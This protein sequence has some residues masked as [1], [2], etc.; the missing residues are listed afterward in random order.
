MSN[1]TVDAKDLTAA[2]TEKT[3]NNLIFKLPTETGYLPNNSNDAF[4]SATTYY[5][6]AQPSSSNTGFTLHV[7]YELTA[8]D[9][10][11]VITVRDARVF[12]P[13]KGV[14]KNT[15]ETT[16]IAAWQPNTQYT[17]TF[18]ITTNTNGKTAEEEIKLTDP[19]VPENKGLYPIIFDNIT[20]EEITNVAY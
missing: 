15:G 6:V 20:I 1:I 10:S 2:T 5:A 16:Y 12:I 14:D 8:A 17:Y 19:S 4:A 9:N 7:S 18:K 11:E 13:A 3:Q